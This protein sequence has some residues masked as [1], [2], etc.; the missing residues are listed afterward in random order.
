MKS[1][2][3]DDDYDFI[4]DDDDGEDKLIYEKNLHIRDA[5]ML[6]VADLIPKLKSRT[7]NPSGGATAGDSGAG[8]GGGG[9]GKKR[10]KGKKGR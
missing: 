7:H 3:E 4:D 10:N 2:L 8:G 6:M 9:G 5:V 1:E